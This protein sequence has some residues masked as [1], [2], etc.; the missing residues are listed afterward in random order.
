MNLISIFLIALSLAMDA[1]AVSLTSGLK[2]KKPT[3]NSATYIGSFFGFF[4][5]FMPLVGYY[6]TYFFVSNLGNFN[7]D[8]YTNFIAF[9]LLILIGGNMLKEAFNSDPEETEDAPNFHLNLAYILPLSVATSIDAFSVGIT[10]ELL[11]V[12]IFSSSILIGVVTLIISVIGVFLGSVL[13]EKLQSKAEIFG[14]LIL[15][16]M[17]INILF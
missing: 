5:F 17:G 8:T 14:G 15:I 11:D 2:L 1:F 4:Q 10:F 6:A 12:K 16:L 13:G 7:I 3:L 9:V